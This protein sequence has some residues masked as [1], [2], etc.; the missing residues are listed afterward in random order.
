MR[1]RARRPAKKCAVEGRARVCSWEL[2]PD[3]HLYVLTSRQNSRGTETFRLF[4]LEAYPYASERLENGEF[5]ID[6]DFRVRQKITQ[7][8]E[9]FDLWQKIGRSYRAA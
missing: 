4:V 2:D 6:G 8:R 7:Y 3:E 5:W 9:I 1:V